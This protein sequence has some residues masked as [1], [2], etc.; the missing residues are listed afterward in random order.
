MDEVWDDH[1]EV[2][3]KDIRSLLGSFLFVGDDVY[4][5]VHELSGGEKARLELTKLSF[6]PINF[7][8]L[9]EPTNHLDIDSRE[10][11][12]SAINEFTGTVLFVSH[13]RYFINQV[14][15]DVLDMRA[16]GIKH[17]EGNYDD[18]LTATA[19]AGPAPSTGSTSAHK[20]PASKGKQS[21]QQSKDQQ[22]A[23]RKLQREVD[24]L[25]KQ[26][27]DL[28]SS[29]AAIQEQMSQP[30][31]ATD[32]GKLTDLQKQLDDLKNQSDEVELAW[33][34]AAEKLEEFDQT[35]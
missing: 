17:Y 27:G 18:Y 21:Y 32:I 3:E 9:D 26:M 33:T 24:R 25:E 1:P 13:D 22:R 29:Q 14:A 2:A 15:T 23:R 35:N 8:I 19:S 16:D 31:V 28:E 34:A 30:E 7:S 10:V 20:E 6:E 11:L 4:K 12:E 5:V